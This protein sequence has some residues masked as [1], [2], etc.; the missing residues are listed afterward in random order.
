M[1]RLSDIKLI[2]IYPL[3]GVAFITYVGG[4]RRTIDF[5][6]IGI[7]ETTTD[8]ASDELPRLEQERWVRTEIKFTHD[9]ELVTDYMKRGQAG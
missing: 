1:A 5:R 8:N 3:G 6:D 2:E 4:E 9:H 7:T